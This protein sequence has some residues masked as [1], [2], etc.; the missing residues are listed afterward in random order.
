FLAT[1]ILLFCLGFNTPNSKR[2]GFLVTR[3]CLTRRAFTALRRGRVFALRGFAI[4][5]TMRLTAIHALLSDNRVRPAD[6]HDVGSLRPYNGSLE[7]GNG[8]RGYRERDCWDYRGR[9]AAAKNPRN[10]WI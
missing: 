8:V 6:G 3:R 2:T 4:L 10:L 9:R 1:L 7:H 5:V